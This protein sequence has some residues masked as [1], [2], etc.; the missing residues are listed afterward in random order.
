M[1]KRD[2]AKLREARGERLFSF[3]FKLQHSLI[4]ATK[5]LS[6]QKGGIGVGQGRRGVGREEER[7]TLKRTSIPKTGE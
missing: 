1:H 2:E 7:E 3:H 5:Q 4:C 6:T